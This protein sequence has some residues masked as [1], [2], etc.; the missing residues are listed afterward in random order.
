MAAER[1]P[2]QP[3][4][5]I[6]TALAWL[7]PGAG[8]AYLGRRIRGLVIFLTVTATFWTGIAIGGVMTVDRVY[9]PWWF[10]A[11]MMTGANGLISW[12]RQDRIYDQLK[13]DPDIQALLRSSYV[14]PTGSQDPPPLMDIAPAAG[15]RHDALQMLVDYKLQQAEGG[16][17][18]LAHPAAGVARA[19]TGI[20]GLMNLLCIFDVLMLGLMGVRGEP[21]ATPAEASG[22]KR[23]DAS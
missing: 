5:L 3:N 21:A 17:V 18:A 22:S 16:S 11:Q 9:Q 1:K 19:Y 13:Q 15:A 7:I 20:A 12:N 23:E 6:A 4:W 14:A 10:V 2:R 8:H